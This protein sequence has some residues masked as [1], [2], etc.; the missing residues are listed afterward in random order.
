MRSPIIWLGSKGSLCAKLRPY[1]AA[2]HR[3]YCE[4]F[5]G[6]AS[7]LLD[8][9]TPAP[10]E[11]YNDLDGRLTGLFRVLA[12]PDLFAAFERKVQA[13]PY[14]KLTR[15]AAQCLAK[16]PAVDEV[17]RAAAFFVLCRQSFGGMVNKSSWGSSVAATTAGQAQSTAAWMNTI[18]RLPEIHRRL[19]KVQIENAHFRNVIPHYDR[20][21]TL[22]YLDPPYLPETRR[23]GGYDVEMTEADHAELLELIGGIDGLALVSGYPSR[24]YDDALAGWRRDEFRVTCRAMGN[25]RAIGNVGAGGCA[26]ETFKRTE[27]VWINPR[28]AKLLGRQ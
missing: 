22:F 16:C 2:P 1:L 19:M 3:T 4:V 6:G 28:L 15:D 9:T 13:T 11:I 24:L 7:L 14:A 25:T 10:V 5:G 26:G 23:A 12:D 18:R 21:E 8:R 20:P 17:S 27:V